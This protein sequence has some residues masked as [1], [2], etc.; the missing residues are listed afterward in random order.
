MWGTSQTSYLIHDDVI[1]GF[2]TSKAKKRRAAKKTM[3]HPG[4]V[5][6][7]AP[8]QPP[9]A[10]S[11]LLNRRMLHHSHR[12]QSCHPWQPACCE[13]RHLHGR[14]H[15]CEGTQVPQQSTL[16]PSP[17]TCGVYSHP[18]VIGLQK[19]NS[20]DATSW[21]SILYFSQK[22]D[23]IHVHFLCSTGTCCRA[24]KVS[25]LNRKH[26][27]W[28]LYKSTV[29]PYKE[30]TLLGQIC[31]SSLKTYFATSEE[32]CITNWRSPGHSFTVNKQEPSG[33]KWQ[34][35]PIHALRMVAKVVFRVVR[36]SGHK[37]LSTKT[38]Y[39]HRRPFE[40]ILS[41]GGLKLWIS[42]LDYT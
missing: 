28:T 27:N 6:G 32:Q 9:R 29:V 24:Q 22:S 26:W 20:Y 41:T 38:G 12:E 5:E 37:M 25:H 36:L 30:G 35:T 8:L 4:N 16:Q 1:F 19:K 18:N 14:F 10:A 13:H 40:S 23:Q 31:Y 11:A 33:T 2:H 21:T 42:E 17:T 15:G 7:V 34:T 3:D 39:G